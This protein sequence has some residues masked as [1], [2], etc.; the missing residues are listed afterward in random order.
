MKYEDFKHELNNLD[1]IGLFFGSFSRESVK[2]VVLDGKFAQVGCVK[3]FSLMLRAPGQDLFMYLSTP[4]NDLQD[5]DTLKIHVL[6][7]EEVVEL[8][9]AL[10]QGVQDVHLKKMIH[11]DIK[12]ENAMIEILSETPFKCKIQFV[13]FASAIKIE[14]PEAIY[15]SEYAFCTDSLRAPEI[16]STR[17]V[18]SKQQFGFTLKNTGFSLKSDAYS[19]GVAISK[20]IEYSSMQTICPD[21][22]EIADKLCFKTPETRLSISD[23][24][25]KVRALMPETVISFSQSSCSES[26]STNPKPVSSATGP[27]P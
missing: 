14:D 12:I 27:K 9:R 5:P 10:L 18:D 11:T 2:D 4:I 13:D 24:L 23:A 8:S 3:H 6:T 21:L 7:K 16:K 20:L 17:M 25:E 15:C 22:K 26:V 1:K 19:V